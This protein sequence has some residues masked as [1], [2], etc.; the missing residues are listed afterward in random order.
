MNGPQELSVT[1]GANDV[2]QRLWTRL[3]G[4]IWHLP[5][6]GWTRVLSPLS[7]VAAL[8]EARRGPGR[9]IPGRGAVRAV[10]RVA[11][12]PVRRWVSVE[13]PKT[14]S[15]TLT[16]AAVVEHL[17]AVSAGHSIRQDYDETYV[18]WL[19]DE[20]AAVRSRGPFDAR[21]VRS[22]SGAVLGWYM[23]YVPEGGIAQVM[24]VGA[25]TSDA[26][27]VLDDLFARCAAQGAAAVQGRLEPRLYDAV[28]ERRLPLR[29]SSQVLI[30]AR[31]PE[32]TRKVLAGESYLTRLDGEWW[33][34]PHLDPFD[35]VPAESAPAR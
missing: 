14:T 1:D 11:S 13:E 33:M 31:D 6:I 22:S 25:T 32:M 5:S 12:L 30:H 7:T 2:M 29:R 28:M 18:R 35:E 26:G 34:A 23:A 20:V 24:Q 21:L 8:V 3:G 27:A 9:P 4:A 15:E 17:E 16:P 10:D 19:F